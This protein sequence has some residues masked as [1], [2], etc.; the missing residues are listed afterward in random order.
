MTAHVVSGYRVSSA[1]PRQH[2][3]RN[4]RPLGHEAELQTQERS[5][6]ADPLLAFGFI[7]PASQTP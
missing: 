5:G 3:H 1:V 4:R 6:I 2:L 7:K